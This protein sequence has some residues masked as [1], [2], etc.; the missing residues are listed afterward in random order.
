MGFDEGS[1]ILGCNVGLFVGTSAETL[2]DVVSESFIMY[3]VS[4]FTFLWSSIV[5]STDIRGD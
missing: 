1:A 4:S 5:G 3:G 2:G